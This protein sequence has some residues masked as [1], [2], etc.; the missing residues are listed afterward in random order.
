MQLIKLVLN[1]RIYVIL[2]VVVILVVP[3]KVK[4]QDPQF[5]QFYAAPL[6]LNP[7]LTGATGQ[8]LP[9][10]AFYVLGA[11]IGAAGGALQSASRT[12]MVRQ[13]LPGRE[14]EGFGL[15]A[16]AGKATSFIAPL[17][18]G[19]ATDLSGS[20]QVGI[21]P[22]IALFIIGLFLLRWVKPD[23]EQAKV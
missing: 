7:A 3:E 17:S 16:L 22:L 14:T 19:L 9:D 23:G 15:Y 21:T 1:S 20:Q 12:M 18:I 2:C 13:A 10:V 6:Y 5:S 4:S 11:L 8:A